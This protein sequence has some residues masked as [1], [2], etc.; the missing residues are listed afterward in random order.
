MCP[1]GSCYL[2]MPAHA[3]TVRSHANAYNNSHAKTNMDGSPGTA[4]LVFVV[5]LIDGGFHRPHPVKVALLWVAIDKLILL[6]HS[7]V[8]LYPID[9]RSSLLLGGRHAARSHQ[10]TQRTSLRC[11]RRGRMHHRIPSDVLC[12]PGGWGLEQKN[13]VRTEKLSDTFVVFLHCWWNWAVRV[14]IH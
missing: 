3:T 1:V 12:L 13:R 9:K 14:A 8:C 11:L 10:P 5:L 4:R 7:Y 6:L 2:M